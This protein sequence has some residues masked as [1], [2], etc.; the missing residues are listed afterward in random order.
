MPNPNLAS[1][2]SLIADPARAA[3]LLSLLDGRVRP[4]GELAYAAGVT[5]QTASAHLG[6]LLD[7]GLL[8]VEPAGRYRYFRLAGTEVAQVLEQLAALEPAVTVRSK[9]LS[10]EARALRNARCCYDHLAGRIGV[11]VTQAMQA[12]GYLAAAA[13]KQ[14]R[15]TPDG[16]AWF[17]KLGIDVAALA[18]GRRGLARQCLDWTERSPHLAGPLGREL[19]TAFYRSGWLRCAG[20]S[21]GVQVTPGGA[22][23][24]RSELGIDAAAG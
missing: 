4:A 23:W 16:G 13:E 17:A 22:I 18:A 9:P 6:K 3:M 11:A 12:R 15:V 14:F 1:V 2:A 20:N 10:R 19:L 21:R 5:P 7:G 24:L 8:A